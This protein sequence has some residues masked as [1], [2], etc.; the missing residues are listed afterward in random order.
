MFSSYA[1]TAVVRFAETLS[2]ELKNYN[3]KINSALGAL[4]HLLDRKEAQKK[5]AL[6]F[7]K[8]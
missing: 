2:M 5:Q 3:I 8:K 1:S 4:I 6:I 7:I